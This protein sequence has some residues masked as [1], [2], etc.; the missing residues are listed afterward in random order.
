MLPNDGMPMID[1]LFTSGA[2]E[3]CGSRAG[4]V[5]FG[6]SPTDCGARLGAVP[7]AGLRE[8]TIPSSVTTAEDRIN[9]SVVADMTGPPDA[10]LPKTL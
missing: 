4:V 9:Q 6:R 2:G 7:W 1:G 10:T 3:V 8:G 5:N